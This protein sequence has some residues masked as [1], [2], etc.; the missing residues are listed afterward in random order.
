MEITILPTFTDFRSYQIDRL[1]N[2]YLYL[3][4]YTRSRILA[5]WYFIKVFQIQL[6]IP[7]SFSSS[8]YLQVLLEIIPETFL[9]FGENRQFG[10]LS[11][12]S[13]RISQTVVTYS[14]QA[15]F[16]FPAF[17]IVQYQ[18]ILMRNK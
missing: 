9:N 17:S 2:G 7:A 13:T 6:I 1:C 18:Y 16:G 5:S 4:V 10:I 12:L 8:R 15:K 14:V 3:T 11:F